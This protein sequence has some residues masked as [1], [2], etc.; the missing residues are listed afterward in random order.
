MT[1]SPEKIA[2]NADFQAE[3]QHRRAE[4]DNPLISYEGAQFEDEAGNLL[5]VVRA[6]QHRSAAGIDDDRLR[7]KVAEAIRGDGSDLCDTPWETLSADRK[8]GWLGDADRALAVVKDYMTTAAMP[9]AW[10]IDAV[11]RDGTHTLRL[12][13]FT[14]PEDAKRYSQ[15]NRDERLVSLYATPPASGKH[16]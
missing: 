12:P 7:H 10:A 4:S 15:A 2:E 14:N 6:D 3:L 16:P 11:L 1:V 13:L 8:V 5:V 9:V